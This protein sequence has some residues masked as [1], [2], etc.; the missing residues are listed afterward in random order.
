[1]WLLIAE[2]VLALGLIVFIMWWTLRA[3]VDHPVEKSDEES[4]QPEALPIDKAKKD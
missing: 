1:M 4:P 2:M 3:R